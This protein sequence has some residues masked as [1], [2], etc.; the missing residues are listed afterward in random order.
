MSAR[1]RVNLILD[2]W[3]KNMYFENLYL[4]LIIYT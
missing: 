3:K 4:Y 1:I 2:F